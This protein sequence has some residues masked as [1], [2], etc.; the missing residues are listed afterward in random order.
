MSTAKG[1]PGG[2]ARIGVFLL[3]LIVLGAGAVWLKLPWWVPG[4]GGGLLIFAF[5]ASIPGVPL[6]FN[7]AWF[8]LALAAFILAA[9]WMV[10]RFNDIP[11][12]DLPDT[13]WVSRKTRRL[14]VSAMMVF[15]FALAT[16][17]GAWL[18]RTRLPKST[19]VRQG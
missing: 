10:A 16:F 17:A 11:L 7:V 18:R 15:T 13:R 19:K 6:T 5:F 4:I 12:M 14:P 2:Y 9:A 1:D 8:A 3:L